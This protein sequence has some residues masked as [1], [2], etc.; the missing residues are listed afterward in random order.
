MKQSYSVMVNYRY[1]L[2]NVHEGAKAY[3]QHAIVPASRSV[4]QLL[5]RNVEK[6]LEQIRSTVFGLK[7]FDSK[8]KKRGEK[9]RL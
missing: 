2:A 4:G 8:K 1:D 9:S 6:S 7:L 5:Y 3:K